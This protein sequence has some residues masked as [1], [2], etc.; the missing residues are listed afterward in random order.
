VPQPAARQLEQVNEDE[1]AED[2]EQDAGH[3]CPDRGPVVIDHLGAEPPVPQRLAH[4]ERLVQR[5]LVRPGHAGAVGEDAIGHGA[6]AAPAADLAVG[7]RE[8]GGAA[9]RAGQIRDPVDQAGQRGYPDPQQDQ[10]HDPAE[11]PREPVPGRVAVG[12]R[13]DRVVRG[14]PHGLPADARVAPAQPYGV[15]HGCDQ[16]DDADDRQQQDEDG[17][18]GQARPAGVGGQRPEQSA[19]RHPGH[20]AD[21]RRPDPAPPSME[22]PDGGCDLWV[23]ISDRRLR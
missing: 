16:R 3:D 18:H 21:H 1:H 7:E 20:D 15:N 23:G 5:H 19:G 6:A 10:H 14:A 2:V 11:H 12:V 13:A 9:F 22:Q 8:E 17:G 4:S